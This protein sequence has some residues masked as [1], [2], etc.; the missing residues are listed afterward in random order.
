[1]TSDPSCSIE[2][3]IALAGGQLAAGEAAA[4]RAHARQ[5]A[6]CA[7][8]LA[9]V[10]ATLDLTAAAPAPSFGP[11]EAPA[12][13]HRVRRGIRERY[14][15]R[16][17]WWRRPWTALASGA[18]GGAVCAALVLGVVGDPVNAPGSRPVAAR[19]EQA[20]RA[21]QGEF[22]PGHGS[23][24]IAPTWPEP[25]DEED[26]TW[27]SVLDAYLIETATEAELL[28]QVE[29]LLEDEAVLTAL[30]AQ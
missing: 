27:A 4:I 2:G 24:G 18:A 14:G 1:M 29:N 21:Q 16:P 5:C 15:V 6:S 7:R 8:D 11:T 10:R 20:A 12:F 23:R 26:R 25:G 13:V 17:V 3:L 30:L 9:E 22:A 19:A 28:S